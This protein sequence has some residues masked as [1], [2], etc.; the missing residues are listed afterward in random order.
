MYCV[1]NLLGCFRGVGRFRIEAKTSPVRKK[2]PPPR[3]GASFKK[4]S[5][6]TK[7]N[8]TDTLGMVQDASK[9]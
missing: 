6:W 5:R 8:L 2:L 7:R 4:G 3:A 9:S 1:T